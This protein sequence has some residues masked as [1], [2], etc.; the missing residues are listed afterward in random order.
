ML[1]M[2]GPHWTACFAKGIHNYTAVPICSFRYNLPASHNL[3]IIYRI[4][5]TIAE[6]GLF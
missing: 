3:S 4:N 5:L 1:T 2:N 6:W